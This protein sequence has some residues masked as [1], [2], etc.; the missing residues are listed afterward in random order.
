MKDKYLILYFIG[1]V[2]F[3]LY[4]LVDYFDLVINFNPSKALNSQD[5][6]KYLVPTFG[7][8][9]AERQAMLESKNVI[10]SNPLFHEVTDI[11]AIDIDTELDFEFAEFLYN[12]FYSHGRI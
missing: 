8:I 7:L 12:K 9:L 6:P 2:A 1:F 3:L 10:C 11:E 4:S 5:L